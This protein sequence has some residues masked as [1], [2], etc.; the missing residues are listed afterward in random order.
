MSARPA[1]K[2][3]EVW[4]NGPFA[5]HEVGKE[6]PPTPAEIRQAIDLENQI[7]ATKKS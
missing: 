7:R 6:P 3:R 5:G 2:A 1:W 4:L